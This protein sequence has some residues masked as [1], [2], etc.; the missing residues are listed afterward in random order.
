[1]AAALLALLLVALAAYALFGTQAPRVSG[2]T[3]VEP[4]RPVAELAPGADVCQLVS[5]PAGTGAVQTLTA[6]AAA[7]GGL[8]LQ[9]R[10]PA[11]DALAGSRAVAARDGGLRFTF[12]RTIRADTPAQLCLRSTGAA[13][14]PLL[15]DLANTGLTRG[16]KKTRGALALI[17]YRPGEETVATLAGLIGERLGRVRGAFGGGW[18][19]PAIVLLLLAALAGTVWTVVAAI[20]RPQRRALWVALFA[21]AACHALAWSLLTPVFQIPDEPAHLSYVQDLVE[22]GQPPRQIGPSFSPQLATLVDVSAVGSVNFNPDGRPPWTA[23]E[24]ASVDQRLAANPDRVNQASYTA[25]ADY[26]PAYYAAMAPVYR[27]VTAAGGNTLDAITPLRAASALLAGVAIIAVFAFLLEL[28]PERRL[29]ALLAALICAWHPVF[30]WISGGVSPDALLIPTGCVMFWLFA[31]AFIRGPTRWIAVGLGLTLAL[32]VL[33]K[34]AALGLIPGWCVGVAVLVWRSRDRLRIA[35][36]AGL[37]ALLPLVTYALLNVTA[38]D[39]PA[40]PLALTGSAAEGGPPAEKSVGTSAGGFATYLWEYVFPRLGGMRDYFHSGWT[41]KD[42]WVPIWVGRF[43]WS[44]YQFPTF[45]N[46]AALVVYAVIAV[47]ALVV[48]VRWLRSRPELRVPAA[49]LAAISLGLVVLIARVGYPLRASGS[50]VFEQGRYY[51]PL[52]PL[53]ALAL[54]LAA[55]LLKPR[56]GRAVLLAFLVGAVLHAGGGLGLTAKRYYTFSGYHTAD[57]RITDAR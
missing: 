40:V 33:T 53:Y 13:P 10:S 54:V 34:V 22:K 45:V 14:V 18:R 2:V 9:L 56:W 30:A 44:D 31:R 15:G 41:P 35:A 50:F 27:A 1:V 17:F 6:G 55:Q 24:D 11:G 43:G 3:R 12:D 32:A 19:A 42:L 20:R 57:G 46:R 7:P 4:E 28:F 52:I 39:R 21:V 25:V 29:L 47:A 36:A 51:M 8:S 23:S 48:L 26:P 5:V 16:G 38:W 49:V 37:A